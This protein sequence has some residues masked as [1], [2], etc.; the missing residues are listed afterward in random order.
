MVKLR[1]LPE[2]RQMRHDDHFVDHLVGRPIETIGRLIPVEEID[3]NPQQPR[4][5]FDDL[6]DLIASIQEKGVLEPL[7]V[8]Q[9]ESGR[10]QIIAG[11]RRFRAA[12]EA[13]LSQ[14]PCIEI[15]VDE[16]G[17]LE[18]SLVENL[19]RR[20]LSPFEE[21]D[22]LAQLR[23]QFGFKHEE[24]ARKLARSRTWVTESLSLAGL[25]P[26]VRRACQEG[27][28]GSR[29]M[30]LQI[31]RQPDDA[32]M[33][34]M[35]TTVSGGQLSREDVRRLIKQDGLALVPEQPASAGGSRGE[36]RGEGYVF[37]Y[38]APD[39]PFS[40]TLKMGDRDNASRSEIIH[41]LEAIIADL[42][43]QS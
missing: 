38:K 26:A 28:I 27:G 1:G 35:I 12:Q 5:Q 11:E 2:G 23:D 19:Q 43:R 33:M 31:A 36:A 18:I 16:R 8:R 25:P 42:R 14:V 20:D 9:L 29:S 39:Q 34:A 3:P 30:L 21:A 15:D 24:I 32:A 10:F 41:A 37:R 40:F 4:R 22:A 7:L 17:C 13:G 6:G